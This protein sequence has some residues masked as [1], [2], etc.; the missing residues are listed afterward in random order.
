MENTVRIYLCNLA[1]LGQRCGYG[2]GSTLEAAIADALA[3]AR[4]NGHADAAFNPDTRQVEFRG[5]V[6][7]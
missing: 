1:V 2:E 4:A 6:Y 5:R 3:Y 7:L